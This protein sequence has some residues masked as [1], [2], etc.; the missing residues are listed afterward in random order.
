MFFK[1][2]INRT[3]I[4]SINIH[5][6]RERTRQALFKGYRDKRVNAIRLPEV[7]GSTTRRVGKTAAMLTEIDEYSKRI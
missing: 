1:Y 5:N 4:G 3:K 6:I 7:L 2:S